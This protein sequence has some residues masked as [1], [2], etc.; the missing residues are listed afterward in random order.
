MC[1][2]FLCALRASVQASL[3]LFNFQGPVRCSLIADSL[4]IISCRRL[5]V[6]HFFQTFLKFVSGDSV[7]EVLRAALSKQLDYY[8]NT[9]SK[10][11][12]LFSSFFD[13]FRVS[14][15]SP[16]SYLF[17]Y[18]RNSRPAGRPSLYK[19]RYCCCISLSRMTSSAGQKVYCGISAGVIQASSM[20]SS[21]CGVP[22]TMRACSSVRWTVRSG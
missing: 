6:K 18:K 8:T 21:S 2:T 19:Y 3:I 17:I 11:Q 7:F 13:F 4:F 16:S 22:C 14:F 20:C 1:R 10:C 12:H 9:P 15:Y 5:F